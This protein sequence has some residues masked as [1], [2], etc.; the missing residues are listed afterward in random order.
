[1]VNGFSHMTCAPASSAALALLLVV[2][3]RAADDDD[4]RL[5]GDDVV[6]VRRGLRECRTSSLIRASSVRVAPVDDGELDLVPVTSTDQVGQVRADGPRPGPDD[7]DDAAWPWSGP[8]FAGA[9][10]ASVGPCGGDDSNGRRAAG[11]GRWLDTVDLAAVEAR[12]RDVAIGDQRRRRG[13]RGGPPREQGSPASRPSRSATRSRTTSTRCAT[14]AWSR[15]RPTTASWAGA[16]RSPSSPRRASRP[17]R[18]SRAWP[19]GW[20]A[21][22]RSTTSRSGT[23]CATRSGGT[24][25]AAASPRTRWP[26]STWRSG[27]SRAS[28]SARACCNLLGGA[29]HERLPVVASCHAHYADIGRDGRGGPGVGGARAP[30]ASRSASASEATRASA[31]STTAMWSTSAAMREG[32]G[33]DQLIMIDCGWNVKWDV[34]TAVRR[35]QA[36]EE[37]GLHWIEEPLRRLGPRGLR[38][39][40][41]QDHQRSSPTARRSG[42]SPAS[43]ASSPPAP[44]TSSGIDPGRAEGITGFK[45][46]TERI[47]CYRRQSNAHCLVVGA[48][49]RR[50]AWRSA[51]A[52]R[53]SSSSSSS[54]CATRCSTTW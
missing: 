35:V 50:P 26:P 41:Q 53:R 14:C 52:P 18:S 48:S 19:S 45:R 10:P 8:P 39:P 47:E 12:S 32:L 28:C 16:N 5:L 44:W 7:A 27:T 3:G 34:M 49:A 2:A 21:R 24:A 33:P 22:T 46:A 23:R 43:S 20:S 9:R 15:S 31:T 36:F 51:S 25:T 37:Y 40:A 1:M 4:V 11:F 13:P 17:R 42:T 29:V 54:R 38:Q 30:R 6:P